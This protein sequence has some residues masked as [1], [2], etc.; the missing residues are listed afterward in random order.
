MSRSISSGRKSSRSGFAATAH[1]WAAGRPL[2]AVLDDDL[3]G[4]IEGAL[5]LDR[6]A[7]KALGARFTWEAATDQFLSAVEGAVRLGEPERG[8]EPA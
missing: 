6:E 1:R 5:R 2:A 7:A 3:T 8:L 4:A